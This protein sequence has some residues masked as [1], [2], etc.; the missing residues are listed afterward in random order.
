MQ[1]LGPTSS[2]ETRKVAECLASA[3]AYL[4]V[5]LKG[6]GL[7]AGFVRLN[8]EHRDDSRQYHLGSVFDADYHRKGY[9]TEA[10][11]AV[12]QRA[13]EEL[14]ADRV[15]IETAIVDVP[16]RGPLEKLGFSC[17]KRFAGSFRN[18]DDG[19]SLEFVRGECVLPVKTARLRAFERA[20]PDGIRA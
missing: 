19:K 14:R 16:S 18:G 7:F 8:E 20:H 10:C 12:I 2:E 15:V 3:D 11:R 1:P 5:C 13:F 9:A 4:A 6:K 17:V